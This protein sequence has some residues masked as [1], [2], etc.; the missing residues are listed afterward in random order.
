MLARPAAAATSG[1]AAVS[2]LLPLSSPLHRIAPLCA[3]QPRVAAA[4]LRALLA[5]VGAGAAVA[6][7]VPEANGH[8]TRLAQ[9]LGLAPTATTLVGMYNGASPALSGAGNAPVCLS[10]E[11]G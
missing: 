3:E 10:A 6:V 7:D 8:L 2:L 4:L 5:R 1:T 9:R 11:L